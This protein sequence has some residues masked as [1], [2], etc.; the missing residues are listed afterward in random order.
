MKTVHKLFSSLKLNFSS[1]FLSSEIFKDL[2][3]VL[4]VSLQS[5]NP[6]SDSLELGLFALEISVSNLKLLH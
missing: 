2:L 4:K 5:V 3:G 1:L 6:V